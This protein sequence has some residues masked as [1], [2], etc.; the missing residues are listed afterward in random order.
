MKNSEVRLSF[1]P[2]GWLKLAGV[3]AAL[4]AALIAASGASAAPNR[5]DMGVYDPV[6]NQMGAGVFYATLDEPL[7]MQKTKL[8]GS[9]FVRIPLNWDRVVCSDRQ[10]A[11]LQTDRPVNQANPNSPEYVWDR[12]GG[13]EFGGWYDYD[14]EVQEA[15][16]KGLEPILSVFGA[17]AFAEC[18]G[19]GTR[20][21]GTGRLRCPNG[22]MPDG[23][24]FRPS[25]ADYA[26]FMKAVAARY[27]Q[28][29]YFQVW[30][31][32]N[33]SFFLK[34]ALAD[35]TIDRYRELVNLT[36][37][38][39][40][41]DPM[42]PHRFV[43]A[44]GTSPNPRTTG[45]K[46]FGPK[47][48][49]QKL[50]EQPVQFDIYDTHPYTQGG[51]QTRAPRGS[52]A[53]WMGDLW[54]LNR[55]LQRGK[56][57]GKIQGRPLRFFAGEFGWDSAPPDCLELHYNEKWGY[58]RAVSNPLLTRWVSESAYQMWRQGVSAMIWGQLKDYP[59]ADNSHQGGLFYQGPNFDTGAAKPAV[60]AF[61]FPF[62]AYERKRGAYVWGRLPD[63]GPGKVVI[64]R[65][66][67]G[68]WEKVKEITAKSGQNGL[69][70][71][72]LY[73]SLSRVTS[74]RAR[75]PGVSG[76]VSAPFSLTVPRTPQ[77]ILPFGCD[78]SSQPVP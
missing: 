31:E 23:A 24:N 74:L 35:E 7:A 68:R 36:Y 39:L 67:R 48:F 54:Q 69:F 76:D 62:V 53:I 13:G 33:Y 52:G 19:L 14:D 3:A 60:Q 73:F 44:G 71:A 11:C 9:H 58:H 40:N 34:P 1:R 8:T 30:N 65:R 26:L 29:R 2:V 50:L 20:A 63:S 43:I 17:P 70:M 32:P 4:A 46:A 77:G 21:A 5:F 28:V 38:A 72:R 51:P 37:N 15:L 45:I 78:A 55:M 18:N 57:D 12:N 66:V 59:I 16:A 64:D 10:T 47:A 25:P 75:V 61:R 22:G 41:G 56:R 49:L 42:D 6:S 27:P